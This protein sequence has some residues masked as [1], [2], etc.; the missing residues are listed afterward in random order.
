MPSERTFSGPYAEN[1][2]ALTMRSGAVRNR[3]I[4]RVLPFEPNYLNAVRLI[5]ETA[6]P[7][8]IVE[9]GAL[10]GGLTAHMSDIAKLVGYS[11]LIIAFDEVSN[12]SSRLPVDGAEFCV[13]DKSILYSDIK[14]RLEYDNS[15]KPP[16]LI[17]HNAFTDIEADF[18]LFLQLMR[19][20]D[21]LITSS[22][23]EKENHDNIMR[24]SEGHFMVMARLC[25]AFGEN[26]ISNPNGF[27]IKI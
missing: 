19:P 21:I 13:M 22:T 24:L 23:S 2:H 9:I 1:G 18:E 26:N 25:D 15:L 12:P 14:E 7:A 4:G 3:Y 10:E 17:V 6:Q 11:A 8:V 20:G 27:L 5:I 16:L